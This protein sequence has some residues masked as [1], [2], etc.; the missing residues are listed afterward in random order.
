MTVVVCG[1]CRTE[2]ANTPEAA[3]VADEEAR[4]LYRDDSEA[5]A[6][7]GEEGPAVLCDDCYQH[8]L[9]WYRD[10]RGNG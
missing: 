1:R 5:L 4:E 9:V 7:L 10:W 3:A 8:F 6:N 2:L